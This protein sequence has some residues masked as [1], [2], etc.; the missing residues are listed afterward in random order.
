MYHILY[1]INEFFGN[2]TMVTRTSRRECVNQSM[3]SYR[4]TLFPQSFET[5]ECLVVELG[6]KRVL[7]ELF[8]PVYNLTTS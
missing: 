1:S 6:T 3:C 2:T 8:N 7:N 5:I 4:N